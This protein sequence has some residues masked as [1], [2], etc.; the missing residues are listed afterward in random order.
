VFRGASEAGL[1]TEGWYALEVVMVEKW[2]AARVESP[3]IL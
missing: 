2:C 1:E 3:L